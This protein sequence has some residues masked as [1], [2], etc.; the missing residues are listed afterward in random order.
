MM[1]EKN[2]ILKKEKN[3]KEK[4]NKL[5]GSRVFPKLKFNVM[6]NVKD[7]EKEIPGEEQLKEYLFN[8]NKNNDELIDFINFMKIISTI[9]K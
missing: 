5:R 9:I 7:L 6:N 2:S 4:K 3:N 1:Q 8:I